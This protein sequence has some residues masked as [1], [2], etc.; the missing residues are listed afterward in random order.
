MTRHQ[1]LTVPLP[2]LLLAANVGFCV[3]CPGEP[4]PPAAEV[5]ELPNPCETVTDSD[6]CGVCSRGYC[7][8]IGD[9]ESLERACIPGADPR[10]GCA[11]VVDALEPPSDLA[12]GPF[13]VNGGVVLLDTDVAQPCESGGFLWHFFATASPSAIPVTGLVQIGE[14]VFASG[15]FVQAPVQDRISTSLVATICL[16]FTENE[17]FRRVGIQ[18]IDA[19]NNRSIRHCGPL[20]L[21]FSDP[22]NL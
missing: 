22:A 2:G 17:L 18:Y 8:R 21:R 9:S 15:A 5:C 1:G 11:E 20:L 6:V 4:P 7:G 10:D 19:D 14:E 16:P 3:A 12:V 13:V